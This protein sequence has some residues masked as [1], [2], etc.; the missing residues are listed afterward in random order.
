MN[1]QAPLRGNAVTA[2][3][4]AAHAAEIVDIVT[5]R[6][7]AGDRTAMRLCR[8]HGLA[9]GPSPELLA[10]RLAASTERARATVAALL[11]EGGLGGTPRFR[12]RFHA[13]R[14]DRP[15][16]PKVIALADVKTRRRTGASRGGAAKRGIAL[17]KNNANTSADAAAKPA[18]DRGPGSGSP[19]SQ[20]G[21]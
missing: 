8:Q 13:G 19:P 9:F 18:V 3:T 10:A 16:G 6:A 4:F 17:V 7:E 11:A 2:A 14:P 12:P 1:A 5:T 21:R 15:D 20:F